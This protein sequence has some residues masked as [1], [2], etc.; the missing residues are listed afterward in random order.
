MADDLF[1]LLAQANDRLKQSRTAVRI[2]LRGKDRAWI[3]LQ[4]T[5]PPK[6]EERRSPYQQKIALGMTADPQ[7][8]KRAEDLAKL[9]GAQLNLGQFTWADWLGTATDRLVVEDWVRLLEEKFWREHDKNSPR[10]RE[11]WRVAYHSVLKTLPMRDT[12]SIEL[13]NKWVPA[14]GAFASRREHYVGCA[15]HLAKLAGLDFNLKNSPRIRRKRDLPSDPQ[16]RQ[17]YDDIDQPDRRWVFGMFVAY[18]LRSHEIFGLELGNYPNIVVRGSAKTGSRVV[19]P[20]FPDEA[21]NSTE[22]IES[23]WDLS[24]ACLPE[25]W[26]KAIGPQDWSKP[27]R[28]N[29]A[30]GL[31][32]T[33]AFW[34]WEIGT[35][36]Y[37]CRHAYARRLKGIGL[38]DWFIARLMGHSVRI[39]Q[40]VYQASFEDKF[41][42]NLIESELEK[43]RQRRPSD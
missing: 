11:T 6:G 39:H 38:D 28:S 41:H 37:G 19:L 29:S 21:E 13:L 43:I 16:L 33:T 42:L 30:F 20:F 12:L 32:P 8:L 2:E 3:Y 17:I 26:T 4:A 15:N 25:S 24:L 23:L 10:D 27:T 36:I 9:I 40:Q 1:T 14:P 7:S 5:F 31:F 18:G 22:M 34:R 35:T